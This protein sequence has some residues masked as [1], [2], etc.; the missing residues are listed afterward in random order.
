LY[1]A[2]RARR[3]RRAIYFL[4]V[5]TG[6]YAEAAVSDG[7]YWTTT[8]LD[9]LR[10]H[11]GEAYLIDCLSDYRWVAQRRDNRETLRADGPEELRDLIVAD[12]TAQP[13]SRSVAVHPA[14]QLP[15]PRRR[16]LLE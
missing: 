3:A 8:P 12:Y 15:A 11:W 5:H 14:A 6:D 13:V 9:E 7:D 16:F 4:V 1:T 10:W 2:R